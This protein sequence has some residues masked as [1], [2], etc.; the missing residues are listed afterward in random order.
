MP[1]A[2][3]CLQRDGLTSQWR[4]MLRPR[5][6]K[7][8]LN[9]RLHHR[10]KLCLRLE[11]SPPQTSTSFV[12]QCHHPW[13]HPSCRLTSWHKHQAL[14]VRLHHRC[15]LAAQSFNCWQM[16]NLR[17]LHLHQGLLQDLHHPHNNRR[18]GLWRKFQTPFPPHQL[19]LG[20]GDVTSALTRAQSRYVYIVGVCHS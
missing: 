1:L 20:R 10:S 18:S 2:A 7:V 16:R 17:S 15:R 13:S 5:K 9:D 14:H 19:R 3:K 8:H 6:R 12:F 4:Q 11:H